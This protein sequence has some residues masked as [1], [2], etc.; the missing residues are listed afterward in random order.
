MQQCVHCVEVI[1]QVKTAVRLTVMAMLTCL[2]GIAVAQMVIARKGNTVGGIK[3]GHGR[4][5]AHILAHTVAQL[6]NCTHRLAGHG[7]QHSGGGM[8][9]VRGREG[10]GFA[11][12]FGHGHSPPLIFFQYCAKACS[13]LLSPG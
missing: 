6:Q 9:A 10:N 4:V 5:A 8:A 13:F 7:V 2:G 3:L 12:E 1:Q 11:V